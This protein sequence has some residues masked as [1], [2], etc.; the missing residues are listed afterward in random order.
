M[1]NVLQAGIVGA[2]TSLTTE[3]SFPSS[4]HVGKVFA[5][6]HRYE[7]EIRDQVIYD[8]APEGS[9]LRPI[10]YVISIK[11][12][13]AN[14]VA[15]ARRKTT[16]VFPSV[17]SCDFIFRHANAFPFGQPLIYF[18]YGKSPTTKVSFSRKIFRFVDTLGIEKILR[19]KIL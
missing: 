12:L 18:Q 9:S 14:P 15:S 19:L 8:I 1:M 3:G 7:V 16:A 6:W 17:A 11:M 10:L 2:C 4:F 5:P 13:G